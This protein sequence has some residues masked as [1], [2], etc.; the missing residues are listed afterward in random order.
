MSPMK[1]HFSVVVAVLVVA[2][3]A[4]V[5]VVAQQNVAKAPSDGFSVSAMATN[6]DKVDGKHSVSAFASKTKRAGKLVATSPKG[7]LPNNIIAKARN[8]DKLDGI[9]SAAFAMKSDILKPKITR[10]K[11]AQVTI[12]GLGHKVATAACPA[13][14]VAVGGGYDGSNYQVVAQDS[15]P[16]NSTTWQVGFDNTA[17][18]NRTG[19]AYVVC[20]A[21]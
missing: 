20:M 21:W 17:V 4:G 2:L 10:V 3:L 7:Y 5:Q 13:G 9:D 1:R 16:L 14:A 6:S 15:F 19:H 8:A 11:G 12:A 18:F